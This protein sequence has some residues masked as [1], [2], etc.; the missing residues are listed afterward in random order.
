MGDRRDWKELVGRRERYEYRLR[1]GTIVVT[2]RV[3]YAPYQ[4]EW[5][6]SVWPGDPKTSPRVKSASF[7][8]Q[9][10]AMRWTGRQA[11]LL[12]E[13]LVKRSRKVQDKLRRKRRR[14]V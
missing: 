9:G 12:F 10:S 13:R 2:A 8:D 14:Y 11:E 4:R 7:D 1:R 5:V 6:G 3:S